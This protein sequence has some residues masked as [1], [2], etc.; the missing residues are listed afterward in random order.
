MRD[1]AKGERKIKKK[2]ADVKQEQIQNMQALLRQWN[3]RP[4]SEKAAEQKKHQLKL[5]AK[6]RVQKQEQLPLYSVPRARDITDN[7]AAAIF[8]SKITPQAEGGGKEDMKH[9]HKKRLPQLYFPETGTPEYDWEAEDWGSSAEESIEDFR[10]RGGKLFGTTYIMAPGSHLSEAEECHIRQV[11]EAT[12]ILDDMIQRRHVTDLLKMVQ[13]PYLTYTQYYRI[14]PPYRQT[15]EK[16]IHYNNL[17]KNTIRIIGA[18]ADMGM[19]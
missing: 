8:D 16:R 19:A 14:G 9:P 13:P 11:K 18:G 17:L 6:I 3:Q 1:E 2:Q 7:Q 15:M 5:D 4:L 10:K 12:A